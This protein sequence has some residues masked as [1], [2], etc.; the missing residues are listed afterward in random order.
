M[1]ELGFFG[2]SFV[3]ALAKQNCTQLNDMGLVYE[4]DDQ[5][6]KSLYRFFMEQ[7]IALESLDEEQLDG[8]YA[9]IGTATKGEYSALGKD[10]VVAIINTKNSEKTKSQSGHY[11]GLAVA[12]L[13]Q[14]GRVNDEIEIDPKIIKE[15][16]QEY[17]KQFGTRSGEKYPIKDITQLAEFASNNKTKFLSQSREDFVKVFGEQEVQDREN[18]GRQDQMNHSPQ[19]EGIAPPDKIM[20]KNE[21]ADYQVRY[22]RGKAICKQ[23]GMN[24]EEMEKGG[25]NGFDF[26]NVVGAL[27]IAD[28][29]KLNKMLPGQQL[30]EGTNGVAIQCLDVGDDSTKSFTNYLFVGDS[31]VPYNDSANDS[32]LNQEFEEKRGS[33]KAIEEEDHDNAPD[34][35]FAKNTTLQSDVDLNTEDPQLQSYI[36]TK[37]D[38]IIQQ[39]KTEVEQAYFSGEQGHAIEERIGDAYGNAYANLVS[40]EQETGVDLSEMTDQIRGKAEENYENADKH[41]LAGFVLGEGFEDRHVEEE[42]QYQRGDLDFNRRP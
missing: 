5:H 42:V 11:T 13:D 34:V 29:T 1:A 38:A 3:S 20:D 28:T 4:N 33:S 40:L 22:E 21:Q 27:K 2:K 24:V 32:I 18:L 30:V 31:T 6:I 35:T 14:D 9:I 25:S 7:G 19:A 39:L 16:Y 10:K 36:Q 23:A 37:I 8:M 26:A 41:A 17:E 12:T 15:Y